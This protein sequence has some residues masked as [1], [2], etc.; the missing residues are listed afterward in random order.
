MTAEIEA[1]PI[2]QHKWVTAI[3]KV[4][5][6]SGSFWYDY[7]MRNNE[8]VAIE[9]SKDKDPQGRRCVNVLVFTKRTVGDVVL[10]AWQEYNRYLVQKGKQ[11]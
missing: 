1:V 5:P 3:T 9:F 8:K 11:K 10:S 7:G 4:S 6:K 2:A